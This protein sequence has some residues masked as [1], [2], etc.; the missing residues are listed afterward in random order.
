[1]WLI[2]GNVQIQLSIKNRIAIGPGLKGMLDG[3]VQCNITALLK[4]VVSVSPPQL[5]LLFDSP[6]FPLA[7]LHF[8]I[9]ACFSPHIP[10]FKKKWVL[11]IEDGWM[12]G[13]F[14]QF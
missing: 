4:C 12:D 14:F 9:L 5:L 2:E 13:L 8:H 10:E 6:P 11:K 1:M 3:P 7:T